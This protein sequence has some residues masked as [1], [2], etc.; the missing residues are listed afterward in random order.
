M[1]VSQWMSWEGGV[2]LVAMSDPGLE[3][4]NVIVHVARLVHTPLGAS[5]AGLIMIPNLDDLTGAPLVMGF[6]AQ[7]VQVG[8]YFGPQ[9][10]ADTPFENAYVLQANIEVQIGS[11]SGAARIEVGEYVIEMLLSDTSAPYIVDRPIGALPFVQQGIERSA[12]AVSLTIN[13]REVPLTVPQIGISGGPAA[14][15]APC[16]LYARP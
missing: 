14:V 13:G 16:G 6:I 10:F 5:P 15:L 11:S 7:E 12:G 1:N 3:S 2:D 8:A 4:P 9:I